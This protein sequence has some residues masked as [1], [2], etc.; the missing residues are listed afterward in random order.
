M[1]TI[2]IECEHSGYACA[3][4]HKCTYI[5]KRGMEVY[6]RTCMHRHPFDAKKTLLKIDS[7]LQITH[8]HACMHTKSH[9][10][11][12]THTHTHPAAA[13]PSDPIPRP[14]AGKQTDPSPQ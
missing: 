4:T 5:H 11:K 9:A 1:T 10:H 2:Y 7:E 13:T 14:A 3:Y 8:T 12:H 6:M